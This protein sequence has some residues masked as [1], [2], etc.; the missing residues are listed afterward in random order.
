MSKNFNKV[1]AG[2]KGK[3][4]QLLGKINQASE[5]GKIVLYKDI[6]H[7]QKI[8]E[9]YDTQI[10]ESLDVDIDITKEIDDVE[11]YHQGVNQ[12]LR[13][14]KPQVSNSSLHTNHSTS[15]FTPQSSIPTQN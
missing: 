15:S 14:I 4:T 2:Y 9:H 8:I 13:T 1:R 11:N 6:I 10:I 7:Y 3:I 12:L 5:E